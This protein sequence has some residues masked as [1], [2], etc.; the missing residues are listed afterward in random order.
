MSFA[1]NCPTQKSRNTVNDNHSS[2]DKNTSS[3]SNVPSSESFDGQS[4]DGKDTWVKCISTS[5][6]LRGVAVRITGITRELAGLQKLSP[7]GSEALGEALLSGLLLASFSKVGERINL[8]VRSSGGVRQALVDAY[9]EGKVRGYVIE[10]PDTAVT[11]YSKTGPWGEG[12]LSVLRTKEMERQQPYIGTV[13]LIT[14]HLAKD[15]TFYWLQSEQ[16]PS[17]VGL[18]IMMG[19]DGE[20]ASAGGFIVQALPGAS[21]KEIDDIQRHVEALGGA[22]GAVAAQGDPVQLLSK[23][24]QDHAFFVLEEKELHW[25]CNCSWER[26]DRALSLIGKEEVERLLVEGQAEVNCDF[27]TKSYIAGTERLEAIL[28]RITAN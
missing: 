22:A 1:S 8:N 7:A 2:D 13:P 3:S 16:V 5:G 15:L 10:T 17:A 18:S 21:E 28:N 26:V 12:T 23:I 11:D 25:E 27:C 6:T 14:G 9:P 20:V 24:F 19:E 4:F